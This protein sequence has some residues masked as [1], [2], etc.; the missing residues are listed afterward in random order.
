MAEKRKFFYGTSAVAA[1]VIVL[2]LVVVLN[3]ISGK[4]LD[5]YKLDLTENE[6]YTIS[7]DT[8]DYLKSLEDV[9]AVKAYFSRKL[10]PG[11]AEVVRQ[12]KTVLD[13]YRTFSNGKVRIEY[14]DPTG[15]EEM[16]RKAQSM[17][18][19]PYRLSTIEESELK[20]Q[21]A[22]MGLVFL[23]GDNREVTPFITSQMLAN[24]EYDITSSI[25]K[26]TASKS[27]TIGFFFGDD[28]HSFD[29]DYKTIK[30]LLQKIYTVRE[31]SLKG[32]EK[33][34]ADI[35]TLVVAGPKTVTPRRQ[36]EIDQYIMRGGRVIFLVD[37][38]SMPPGYLQGMPLDPGLGPMLAHYGIK[39]GNDLVLDAS[40]AMAGFQQGGGTFI[41]PYYFW[42]KLTKDCFSSANPAVAKLD[43]VVL[44]WTQ[45]LEAL[46]DPDDQFKVATVLTSS[47]RAWDVKGYYNLNPVLSSPVRE[48]DIK[49]FNLCLVSS[50]KF[51]SFFKGKEIPK[52]AG[53]EGSQQSSAQD[54]GAI[55]ESSPVTRVLVIGNS[56]LIADA[57]FL[58]QYPMNA[59]LFLNLV[60]W[61]A[62]GQ[63]LMNIRSK[64]QVDRPLEV[65]PA[66]KTLA[67]ILNIAGIPIVLLI[68]GLVRYVAKRRSRR[69]LESLSL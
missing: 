61:M 29:R 39:L 6:L 67:E 5:R 41:T 22:Y 54:T 3:F 57:P 44:P 9:V 15:N 47:P 28:G 34:P 59:N 45:S 66:G 17:G 31:V 20:V 8:R 21:M 38:I 48:E 35:D 36:F 33:V 69:I 63:G 32:T 11:Q 53:E 60:D 42:P 18:I 27:R 16:E 19:L 25:M 49:K 26:V 52:P 2:G 23:Y 14:I 65:T 37:S 7:K 13:E 64:T 24:L 43:S 58:M 56:F 10:P 62:L 30:Q 1:G 4:W 51:T 55:T 46:Q 68:F 12:I 40:R 50:G